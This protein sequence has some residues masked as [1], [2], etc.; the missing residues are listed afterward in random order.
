M[1]TD[2][3]TKEARI[4]KMVKRVLTDIAK[5]T[6]TP[7]NVKHPLAPNTIQGIRECL[8]LI[9][10]RETELAEA[11]GKTLSDRPRFIDEP[12]D[13]VVV[14]LDLASMKKGLNKD[15]AGN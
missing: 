11:A 6:Y 5:D 3:S 1:N 7:P 10:T 15:D 2:E 12:K 4:L 9:S 13:K 8:S 14:A